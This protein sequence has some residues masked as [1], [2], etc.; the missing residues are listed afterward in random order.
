[1]VRECADASRERVDAC[2]VEEALGGLVVSGDGQPPILDGVSVS[3][4]GL[5]GSEPARP[6]FI[7]HVPQGADPDAKRTMLK[8]INT[9]V[10]EAYR[11]PEFMTF[12]HE[13]AL[14]LVAFDGGLLADDRQRGEDQ[15]EV[16][17]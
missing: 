4:N 12:I 3:Q 10:T 15:A 1:M 5:L 2:C 8:K 6:V 13:H 14:D 9:V 17:G 11:L 16:Y 7:M